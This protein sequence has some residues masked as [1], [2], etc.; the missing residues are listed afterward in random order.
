M[1]VCEFFRL[2]RRN[3]PNKAGLKK[4]CLSIRL[5]NLVDEWH[6]MVCRM[7]QFTVKVMEVWQLQKWPISKAISSTSMHVIKRLMVNY[8]TPRQSLN[9]NWTDFWYISSFR[10]TWHSNLRWFQDFT[11]D[12]RIL[13][14]STGRPV[15]GCFFQ[16]SSLL[17][18]WQH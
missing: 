7:T 8:D 6:M 12:K 13:P 9:F 11:F 16:S 18:V 14:E 1:S 10:V 3:R 5:R 17:L 4:I 15:G 2:T